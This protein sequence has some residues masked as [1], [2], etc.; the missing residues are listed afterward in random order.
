MHNDDL[1]IDTDYLKVSGKGTLDFSTEAVDYRL[2]ARVE[3]PARGTAGALANLQGTEIP[4]TVS[5]TL[6]R[7][8][9]RPDV[10]ALV[11]GKLRQDLRQR[12]ND[13]LKSLLG[14]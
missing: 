6:S 4:L 9:V 2:M 10:Q 7:L 12:L 8:S 1:R 13:T 5:G 11:Q 14:H 3:G